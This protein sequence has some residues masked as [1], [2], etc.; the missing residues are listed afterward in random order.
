MATD[1]TIG[2]NRETKDRLQAMKREGETWDECLNRVLDDAEDLG[3]V[4]DRLA[5]LEE[6]V[7]RIPSRTAD[8]LAERFR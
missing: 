5:R 8:D 3:E 6:Q 2:V 1:T 4:G 7:E